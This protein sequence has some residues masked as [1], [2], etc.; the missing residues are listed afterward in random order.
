MR[1]LTSERHAVRNINRKANLARH[2]W[3]AGGKED[4][5]ATSAPSTLRLNIVQ[6][7]SE[8]GSNGSFFRRRVRT[9]SHLASIEAVLSG[10][11]D[12]FLTRGG[13]KNR[14]IA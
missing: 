13:S 12:G 6:W 5:I 9:G 1:L 3:P 7:H 10:Q 14:Q 8:D 4:E 2:H 11:I